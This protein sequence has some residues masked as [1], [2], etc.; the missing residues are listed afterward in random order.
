MKRVFIYSSRSLFSQ[1]IKNLLD[2][3]PELD[4]IGWE[5]DYEEAISR[6]QTLHPDAILI[7]TKGASTCLQP[8]GQRFLQVG[9]KARIVELSLE[10]SRM[11]VYS[12]EQLTIT[13]VKDLVRVI[14]DPIPLSP[15]GSVE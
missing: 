11:Q 6:V 7:V 12:G 5:T 8:E 3:E 10:D 1:G 14:E 9:G 13:E 4:V 15:T 2:G